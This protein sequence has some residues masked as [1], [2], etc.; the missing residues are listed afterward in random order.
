MRK[1]I[2]LTVMAVT[3]AV[4]AM[5]TSCST[6]DILPGAQEKD[7]SSMVTMLPQDTKSFLVLD[8]WRMRSDQEMTTVYNQL[9]SRDLPILSYLGINPL[10][11]EYITRVE[12]ATLIHGTH[13]K[14]AVT[15]ALEKDGAG[16]DTYMGVDVWELKSWQKRAT[17]VILDDMIVVG[18][19]KDVQNYIR[20]SQGQLGSLNDVDFTELIERLPEGLLVGV[21]E[22]SFEDFTYKGASASAISLAKKDSKTLVAT[23]VVKF[24]DADSALKAIEPPKGNGR[25][26][27]ARGPWSN[28]TTIQDD[29]FLK[30]TAE[31]GL[32]ITLEDLQ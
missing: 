27:H 18:P 9:L 32:E 28:I 14:D 17:V 2:Y 10:F 29:E 11:V 23:V 25:K 26:N 16:T 1:G 8:V 22:G 4:A 30:I 15:A 21:R 19:R 24:E 6:D 12:Q 31:H 20:V 3:V 7:V 5:L 13:I